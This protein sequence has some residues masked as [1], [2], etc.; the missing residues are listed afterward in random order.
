MVKKLT[1]AATLDP[2]FLQ[3]V[4]RQA[5]YQCRADGSGFYLWDPEQERLSLVATHNLPRVP[6]D[7]GMPERVIA[8]GEAMTET[9][10]DQAVSLAA[11]LIWQDA[12]RGVLIVF[13]R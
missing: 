8:F 3:G 2:D 13:D 5:S 12:V 9:C 11:P 10:S 4:V 7:D 6:W 1:P